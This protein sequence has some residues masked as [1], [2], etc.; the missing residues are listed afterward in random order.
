M[1][2]RTLTRPTRA[3]HLAANV[4]PHRAKRGDVEVR[5]DFAGRRRAR[6]VTRDPVA[7]MRLPRELRWT[8][9]AWRKLHQASGFPMTAGA[10][11]LQGGTGT[12][13]PAQLG[14]GPRSAEYLAS[15]AGIAEACGLDTEA[16]ATLV[17]LQG[18][19]VGEVARMRGRGH[20]RGE[21]WVSRE[22]RRALTVL[23]DRGL[24]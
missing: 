13:G 17:V 4:D 1:T 7:M 24:V 6:A 16:V 11:A 23:R 10:Q 8:A 12:P 5:E 15:K 19:T 22:V 20:S 18:Y 14:T 21:A 3:D 9:E 2:Y